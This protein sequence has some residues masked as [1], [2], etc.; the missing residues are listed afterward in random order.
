MCIADGA[1][2][3]KDCLA[4][5]KKG[6][7]PE[8]IGKQATILGTSSRTAGGRGVVGLSEHS[9]T[10]ASVYRGSPRPPPSA[11]GRMQWFPGPPLTDKD[12]CKR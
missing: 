1:V 2:G 8:R 11:A 7:S 6:D 12:E 5:M 9:E 3:K 4:E 10:G